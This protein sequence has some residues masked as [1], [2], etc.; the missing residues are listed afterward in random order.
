MN[1]ILSKMKH[2]LKFGKKQKKNVSMSS[3]FGHQYQLK[4]ISEFE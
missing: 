3:K 2:Y 1:T 4:G